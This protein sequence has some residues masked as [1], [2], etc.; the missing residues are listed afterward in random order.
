MSTIDSSN[1]YTH[2]IIGSG[3]SGL[4]TAIKLKLSGNSSFIII[5]KK[6]SLGGTWE[7]N[8]Y[9]GAECDVE[10][11]LYSFSFLPKFNWKN[12]YGTQPEILNYLEF[13]A[14]TYDL[15][16]QILFNES[17]LSSK[18]DRTSNAL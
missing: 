17:L 18:F 1:F 10:S 15:R 13:C 8:N 5:E 3:F 7:A 16:S 12:T 4:L 9:P 2:V 11:P 6:L 14:E